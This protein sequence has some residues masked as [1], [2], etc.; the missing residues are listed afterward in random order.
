MNDALH[1]DPE[2]TVSTLRGE[3]IRDCE[4][5]LEYVF[6]VVT[7]RLRYL[8]EHDMRHWDGEP[9]TVIIVPS[10]EVLYGLRN[11]SGIIAERLARMCRPA[12]VSLRLV[13]ATPAVPH[14]GAD[15][16]T[17]Y[18]L[19]S[20]GGSSLLRAFARDPELTTVT[21]HHVS[22]AELVG[23]TELDLMRKVVVPATVGREA[24][25]GLPPVL[26]LDAAEVV[27][28][29]PDVAPPVIRADND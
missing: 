10:S 6:Q 16:E 20:F 5:T 25:S 19:S 24:N 29:D 21:F 8:A 11:Q 15:G 1:L 27:T 18:A 3:D 7:S 28:E 23:L 12:G 17:V 14:A 9:T 4:D 22:P 2:I 26:Q 13:D